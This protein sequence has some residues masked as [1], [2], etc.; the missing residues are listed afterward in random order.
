MTRLTCAPTSRLVQHADPALPPAV[1]WAKAVGVFVGVFM[2]MLAV[3][4][5]REPVSS[6]GNGV[7]CV[8]TL[9]AP[10][11]VR[12]KIFGL[13]SIA[14]TRLSARGSGA[15]KRFQHKNVNSVAGAAI[16]ATQGNGHVSVRI[17]ARLNDFGFDRVRPTI[18]ARY[19]TR[20]GA[21]TTVIRDGIKAFPARDCHPL[22]DITSH[23]LNIVDCCEAIQ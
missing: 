3:R 19:R 8:R 1:V 5:S 9:T 23:A 4:F 22:F 2:P 21:H 12:Q 13:I 18:S 20:L 14:V 11:E 10:V 6:M 16:T 7:Q 17:H 15:N